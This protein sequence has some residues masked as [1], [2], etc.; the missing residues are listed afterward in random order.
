ML[1]K[2]GQ[3]F[4]TLFICSDIL[5]ILLVWFILYV[6]AG[7]L[8]P[9]RVVSIED[10]LSQLRFFT[11]FIPVY[12]LSAQK[13][14]FYAPRRFNS[15]YSELIKILK[16]I[17]SASIISIF[18]AYVSRTLEFNR[19]FILFFL[20]VSVAL[21]FIYHVLVEYILKR[22]RA[23]GFNSRKILIVGCG[24]LAKKFALKFLGHREFGLNVVG[25][26]ANKKDNLA[27][28]S[29]T[30]VLGK[31]EDLQKIILQQSPDIV[32]FALSA[33]EERLM[34][35]LI[36][37]ISSEVVDIK[38]AFDIEEIFLLKNSISEVDGIPIVTLRERHFIGF[39]GIM[40]RI[41]DFIFALVIILAAAPLFAL[42][43][44]L[45]K[46][47]SPGSVFYF[48]DRISLDG[49][50]FR[51]IKFRTMHEDAEK[52]TGPIW[53]VVNDSRRTKIGVWLRRTGLDELPQFINVLK[54]EMSI[55][56]PR[57]DRP[58]F[59]EEFKKLY[60]HYM[61]RH[62]VKSGITGWAQV[63]GLRGNT[64]LAS[65]LKYDF[66]YINNFSLW[67]DIKIIFMTI[68]AIFEGKG[69]C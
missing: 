6:T 64:P 52:Y 5:L 9:N 34:R 59:L 39:Q 26:V 36:E 53:A 51:L 10:F 43:A 24:D 49:R 33:N 22:F 31:Y 37:K 61:F 55:V 11:I 45:V 69:A 19:I 1:R 29:G 41:F 28:I 23:K 20:G 7:Y 58:E 65:R 62:A 42:I 4:I 14:D 15:Y 68:P 21:V 46:I 66:Y 8:S 32:F 67:L 57:P 30:P 54:G 16:V 60:P 25:F 56:G 3:V 63:H 50:K 13:F 40:K 35:S 47:F 44:V 48:Q 27:D 2:Y 12:I 17:S 38:I 18:L